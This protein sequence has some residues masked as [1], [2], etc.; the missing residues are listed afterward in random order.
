[1]VTGMIIIMKNN[2]YYYYRAVCAPLSSEQN[3]KVSPSI[4]F[5]YQV[6]FA[7]SIQKFIQVH[8]HFTVENIGNM[9]MTTCNDDMQIP[10]P[11]K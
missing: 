2:N 8:T 4:R 6:T 5:S 9:N 11:T 1:M 3:R 7:V 10:Q